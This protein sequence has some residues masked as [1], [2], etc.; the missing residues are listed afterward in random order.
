MKRWW[1]WCLALLVTVAHAGAYEDFF[2]AVAMDDGSTLLTLLVRGF[3]PNARDESGQVALLLSL[4]EGSFKAAEALMKSPQLQV[5]LANPAGETPLMMAALKGHG[6]WVERLVER[7]AQLNRPGWSPLHYAAT[8]PE[9][10]IVRWMLDRGAAI[11]AR[12]PNGTTP[13]M[14][15]ARYGNE[16]AAVLLLARGAD[17]RLRNERNLGAGDFARMAGRDRLGEQLDAAAR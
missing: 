8:G 4:R 7:G 9:P 1:A 12:S 14:M 10:A 15:A 13:L 11:N 16:D 3:D 2:K 17:A 5:D 6:D